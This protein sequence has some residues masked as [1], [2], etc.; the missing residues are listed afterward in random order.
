MPSRARYALARGESQDLKTASTAP[1]SCSYGSDG[2]TTSF[3][4]S[5]TC[6]ASSFAFASSPA[7]CVSAGS[8]SSA[9]RTVFA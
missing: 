8:L 9:P 4:A 6:T 2:T 7:W 1:R 3:A 5:N